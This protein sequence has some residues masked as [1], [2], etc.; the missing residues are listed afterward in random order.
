MTPRAAGEG[1][2]LPKIA[3]ASG[4]TSSFRSRSGGTWISITFN[5]N[6]RSCRNPPRRTASCRSAFV[7][8]SSRTSARR[9]SLEPRR[10]YSPFWSTRSSFA[11]PAGERLPIS[12]RK[13]VP[14]FAD[15][16]R[17]MRSRVAPVNA[18]A[19]APNN[20]LSSNWSGSA[21][22]FTFTKAV[23]R[24]PEFAWMISAIFSLPA[25]FGPV[26]STG[27]SAAA[28]CNASVTTRCIAADSYTIPRRSNV[29]AS[30][31]REPRRSRSRRRDS[32]SA[33]TIV[34]SFSSFHGFER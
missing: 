19:S 31:A 28:T 21:P 25:P 12:S 7:A 32:S 34:S 33:V 1:R 18:P 26:I 3:S 5:R 8:Q 4:S 2:N 15:S 24:R 6:N 14:P 11:C 17:P 9:V 29:R 27:T 22:A 10:S 30:A 16:N 20:S 23:F 13:S